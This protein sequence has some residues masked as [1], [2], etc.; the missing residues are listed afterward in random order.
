MTAPKLESAGFGWLIADGARYEH[1]LLI[2][3]DGAILPRPK[4]LSKKYGGWHTVLGPEEIEPAFV[5]APEVLLVGL[6]HFR[7]LPILPETKALLAQRGVTLETA[8]AP[9]AL[10][11]YD[12]LRQTGKRVAAILH[13]T[14]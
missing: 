11:R 8:S 4:H 7:Q 1:D 6:G 10:R 13:V 12:E 2:T 14:C 5:G 9:D 3:A